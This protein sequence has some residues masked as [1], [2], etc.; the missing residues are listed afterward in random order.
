MCEIKVCSKCHVIK[1]DPRLAGA[2]EETKGGGED[3]NEDGEVGGGDHVCKK[4]D[5]ETAQL[6]AKNTKPCPKC[7]MGIFK[8]SG[9][10][11]MYCISCHTAF[12]WNTGK[13]INKNIHNPHYF[14]Y[15]G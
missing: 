6:L 12:C 10:S 3:G 7:S 5:L 13:I 8:I 11:Q 1:E 9:C 4:E 14:E 2:H 15:P